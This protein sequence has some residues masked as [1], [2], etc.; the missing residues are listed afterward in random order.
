MA[1]LPVLEERVVAPVEERVVKAAVEGVEAPIAVVLI[2]VEV[3]LKLAEEMVRLFPPREIE[4]ALK[5]E[6]FRVPLVAVRLSA[7]EERVKPLEAVSNWVVVRYPL[8]VVVTPLAPRVIA[9]V[10]VV[11]IL[12][13]PLVAP[14]P[15]LM[16]TLPP[17]PLVPVSLPALK[18][19][20]PPL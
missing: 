2:P 9:E 1:V 20:P 8:L 15:A 10:L 19:K 3:V 12:T 7:P 18:F 4:E 11:P 6:R 13:V 16:I 5:P 17:V 14:V